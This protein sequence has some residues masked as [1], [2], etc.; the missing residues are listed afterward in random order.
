MLVNAAA[1]AAI[2][3]SFKSVF[4]TAFEGAKPK[5]QAV[6]TR[7]ESTSSEN[8]Y[9][10]LGSWPKMREWVG[11]RQVKNL[12]AHQ[13]TIRN[14]DFEATVAVDR[15]SIEDD[16]L[17]IYAPLVQSMADE[18]A[19]YPDAYV[20]D[21]LAKGFEN[22]CYDGKPFF[23]TTHPEGRRKVA[24]RTTAKL[25]GP[26][27]DAA[28]TAI[29]SRTNGEGKSLGLIPNLLVVAPD[30]EATARE[31][32]YA[33]QI[34]G[35]TN[36]RKGT[37]ELLVVPELADYPG[38]WFLLCTTRPLKPL[39]FQERKKPKIVSMTNE[40][41]TAVFMNKKFIY[42]VDSRAAFGYGMWQMAYG[43]DGSEDK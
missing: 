8:N 32:L 2:F 43:S 29:M 3:T 20:F 27:Y 25:A 30:L 18:A 19:T 12:E 42:G 21:L 4:Q 41:D 1:L 33:D 22:K 24:N 39:I 17:G 26:A 7:V 6:A 5:W 38:R 23:D 35:T 37:A 34:A 13:Y 40:T 36:V 16:Q 15:N 28:R 11:E 31:L 9:G 10:W 14:K